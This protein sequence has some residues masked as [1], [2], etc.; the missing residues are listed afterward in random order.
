MSDSIKMMESV[1]AWAKFG[2]RVSSKLCRVRHIDESDDRTL[3]RII[4]MSN[5]ILCHDCRGCGRGI[6]GRTC[7]IC[8]GTGEKAYDPMLK[9]VKEVMNT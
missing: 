9:I 3:D 2:E 7:R 8:G 4:E 1:L 5:K 6:S